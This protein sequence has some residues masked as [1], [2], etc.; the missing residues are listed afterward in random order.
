[1]GLFACAAG[2]VG[3]GGVAGAEESSGSVE[4]GEE[5]EEGEGEVVMSSGLAA[6]KRQGDLPWWSYESG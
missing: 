3:S 5:A 2:W 1:L 6:G 4:V